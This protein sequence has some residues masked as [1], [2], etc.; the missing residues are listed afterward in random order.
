MAPYSVIGLSTPIRSGSYFQFDIAADGPRLKFL[1]VIAVH[2][3]FYLAIRVCRRWKAK[4]VV[5]VLE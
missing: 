2:S 5:T 4:T 1:N 3:R